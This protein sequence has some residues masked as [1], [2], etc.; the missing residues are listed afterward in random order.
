MLRYCLVLLFRS[1]KQTHTQK[2]TLFVGFSLYPVTFVNVPNFVVLKKKTVFHVLFLLMI[3]PGLFL[4]SRYCHTSLIF[5]HFSFTCIHR[6]TCR[7]FVFSAQHY[8]QKR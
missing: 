8:V 2:K 1:L 5:A 6:K 7:V 4:H 3:N